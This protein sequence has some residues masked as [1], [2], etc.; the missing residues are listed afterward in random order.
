MPKFLVTIRVVVEAD[1]ADDAVLAATC[2]TAGLSQVDPQPFVVPDTG[3]K[4]SNV[5][6]GV[7][8]TVREVGPGTPYQTQFSNY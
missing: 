3:R 5:E 4:P 6:D 8:I 7:Q 1:S 2:E